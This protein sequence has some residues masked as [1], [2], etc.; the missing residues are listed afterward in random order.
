MNG[1]RRTLQENYR[2]LVQNLEITKKVLMEEMHRGK[3][4]EMNKDKLTYDLDHITKQ[5]ECIF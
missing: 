2:T 5:C 1:T 3:E 4:I